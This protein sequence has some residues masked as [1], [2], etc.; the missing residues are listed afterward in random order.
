MLVREGICGSLRCL[1]NDLSAPQNR[2]KQHFGRIWIK[3]V[4]LMKK[5][6]IIFGSTT[7]NTE[8]V[9]DMIAAGLL[10]MDPTV[11]TDLIGIVLM[12]AVVLWLYTGS[13]K[14]ANAA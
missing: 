12:A 1:R 3:D 4:Y 8:T 7:G 11:T 13:K 9:A 6:T 2:W 5:A 14:K 10:M